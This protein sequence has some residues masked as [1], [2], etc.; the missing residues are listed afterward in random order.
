VDYTISDKTGKIYTNKAKGKTDFV[1][2]YYF[3]RREEKW[4]LDRIENDV[5]LGKILKAKEIVD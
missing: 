5:S 4:F 1:D 2:L 3:L